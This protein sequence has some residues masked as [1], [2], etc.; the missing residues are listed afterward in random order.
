MYRV[1][2]DYLDIDVCSYPQIKKEETM[3]EVYIGVDVGKSGGVGIIIDN[4]KKS[5]RRA[6]R[7]VP[8]HNIIRD[9]I[10]SITDGVNG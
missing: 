6:I 7:Y 2:D 10:E 8:D 3:K 9:T 5:C 1:L 4:G